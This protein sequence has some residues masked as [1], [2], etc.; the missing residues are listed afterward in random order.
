MPPFVKVGGE[1]GGFAAQHADM[2]ID[3]GALLCARALREE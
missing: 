3:S 2:R 1:F